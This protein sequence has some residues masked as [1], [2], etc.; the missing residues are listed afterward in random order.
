[1]AMPSCVR[2]ADDP[3]HVS[4]LLDLIEH[5]VSHVRPAYGRVSTRTVW[6]AVIGDSVVL[7][8]RA[9][10]QARWTDDRPVETASLHNPFHFG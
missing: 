8:S 3:P 5:E 10:R 9:V 7:P 1:M 6:Q 4:G 2:D